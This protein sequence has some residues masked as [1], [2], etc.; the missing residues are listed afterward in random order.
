MMP[1][2]ISELRNRAE[3]GEPRAQYLLAAA[4]ASSGARDEA[5][6][7]LHAAAKNGEADASYT[8]ATRQLQTHKGAASAHELLK[9][10][11][12][13]G[14]TVARRLLAVLV[15]E[16]IGAEADWRGAV[17]LVVAA[18][19]EGDASAQ[20]EIAMLLLLADADDADAVH[21]LDR[22]AAQD[23]VAA[24]VCV[25]RSIRL[26]AADTRIRSLL[27][28]LGALRYPNAGSL[29]AALKQATLS[30][31]PQQVTSSHAALDWERVQGKLDGDAPLAPPV[32][33]ELCAAPDA[34]I[35]RGAFSAEACEYV[36]ACASRHLAPSHTVDPR[37]GASRQDAYRTSLTATLGPV[38]LD[39]A[40]VAVNRRVAHLVGSPHGN[41]EFLSV[42][43]YSSGQEYKPHFDWLPPGDDFD[44]GG[45]RVTTALIYLNDDY[46]GGETHF[47]GPDIQ[48]KGAPG[49]VLIFQNALPDG[50]PDKGSRHAS[51]P[52]TQGAKWLGSKWFRGKKYNF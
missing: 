34:K 12:Q 26:G 46:E 8:L 41:G 37:T 32:V 45:Q 50:L 42:L 5:D 10:A 4:L 49:D 27:Q 20:R 21:L 15:A 51:L 3:A 39:L 7:W 40:L 1:P 33:E 43:H 30:S 14:S 13:H 24:A 52:V 17:S 18:A 19:Q 16:G 6:Q 2:N 44:R 36:I 29:T 35:I 38:D 31:S 11:A 22:A 48:F 9:G 23:A 47:L 28:N 25:R